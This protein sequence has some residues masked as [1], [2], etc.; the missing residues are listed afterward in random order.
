MDYNPPDNVGAFRH[1][2]AFVDFRK[3]VFVSLDGH[4]VGKHE[5]GGLTRCNELGFSFDPYAGYIDADEELE[6]GRYDDVYRLVVEHAA[7]PE[8]YVSSK[9]IE[10]NG[11]WE[12]REVA[13]L[14]IADGPGF[15]E[16]LGSITDS[17]GA[18]VNVSLQYDAAGYTFLFERFENV[19]EADSSILA[20]AGDIPL[21]M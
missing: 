6:D 20:I 16:S 9:R 1:E 13:R 14:F 2:R 12:E 17:A 19:T 21:T 5:T 7:F 3:M 10:V 15:T 8:F 4:V 11:T 18:V